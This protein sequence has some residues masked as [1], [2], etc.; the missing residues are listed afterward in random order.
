MSYEVEVK[1]RLVD[2]DQL[3]ERLVQTGRR[4]RRGDRPGGHLSQPPVARLRPHQRGLSHPPASDRKIGSP[5]KVPGG[6]GPP[7]PARRSRSSSPPGTTSCADCSVCSR[8]WDS[9]PSP[10][11]ASDA[12]AF[13]LTF[14]GTTSKSRSTRP[15]V[16]VIS[17]RSRPWPRPRPIFRRPSRPSSPSPAALGLTEVEPRSYLRMVLEN[18]GR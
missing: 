1:Y 8:S 10:R 16:W 2:H 15:R 14:H 4:R 5:I 13:H 18:A 9:A 11:S 3:G 17:P 12:N 6:A 7:R